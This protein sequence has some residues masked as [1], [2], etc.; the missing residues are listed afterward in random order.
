MSHIRVFLSLLVLLYAMAV[1][2]V[3]QEAVDVGRLDAIKYMLFDL[4]IGEATLQGFRQGREEMRKANPALA[5]DFA[6]LD[7]ELTITFLVDRMAPVYATYL[8]GAQAEELRQFFRVPPGS[9][10][11]LKHLYG[12][13][14]AQPLQ[15]Y[16]TPE[17]EKRVSRFIAQS[18]AWK[19]YT[20]AAPS[21]ATRLRGD[22]RALGDEYLRKRYQ[23]AAEAL[24]NRLENKELAVTSEQA[25]KPLADIDFGEQGLIGGFL[26]LMSEAQRRNV[27]AI[28]QF[29]QRQQAIGLTNLLAPNKLVEQE[30]IATGR[31]KLDRYES[32]LSAALR[33]LNGNND[34]V[35]AALRRLGG[36][37]LSSNP[38]LQ[39]AE[40]GVTKLIERVARME[41]NQRRLISL[42]RRMLDLADSRYGSIREVDGKLIFAQ[43]ADL[44]VY[45]SIR[46]QLLAEAKVEQALAKEEAEAASTAAGRLRNLGTTESAR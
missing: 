15:T 14:G 36:G 30:G 29:S 8:T 12:N 9:A 23:A 46:Q 41:E 11:W 2:A 19:A 40:Q 28:R 21:I 5:K 4:K 42:M 1:P 6:A 32:E 33:Q 7:R 17:E 20:A 22:F 26:A 34:D 44:D 27:E 39:G 3:A 43:T 16:L 24:A 38:L 45:E 25:G 31:G 35:V 37:S 13:S 10:F 18:G